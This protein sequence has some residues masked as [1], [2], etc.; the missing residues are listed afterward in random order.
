MEVPEICL[1][2]SSLNVFTVKT[3]EIS[4]ASLVYST[5]RA[6]TV[7]ILKETNELNLLKQKH[8]NSKFDYDH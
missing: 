8:Q 2:D 4:N 6:S 5:V 1:S 7:A 3:G